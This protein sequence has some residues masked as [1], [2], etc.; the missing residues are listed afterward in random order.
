MSLHDSVCVCV[1]VNVLYLYLSSVCEFE[2]A[3]SQCVCACGCVCVF[4]A[5]FGRGGFDFSPASGD[6]PTA[7]GSREYMDE[8]EQE[9]QELLDPDEDD[10]EV[11]RARP[12]ADATDVGEKSPFPAYRRTR[13]AP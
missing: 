10:R 2:C 3:L 9:M 8:E 5:A 11:K 7:A 13:D 12:S 6:T 1:H 4:G